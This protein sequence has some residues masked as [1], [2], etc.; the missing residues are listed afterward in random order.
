MDMPPPQAST[1]DIAPA[2]LTVD[3]GAIAA[4]WRMLAERS[5]RAETSAVLKADAYGLGAAPVAQALSG[6]GC[7][8]FFVAT[9]TEGAELRSTLPD[10]RIFVLSGLWAGWE[11]QCFAN[12]LIPVI[13][14]V[15]Q[16]DFF[17]GLGRTHPHALY[18]DTGM[19][20]L[21]V[22]PEEAARLSTSGVA[23]P[24]MLMSHLA[25]SDEPTHPL[26]RQQLESFRT[27]SRLFPG[28]ESSLSSSAG[29]FLGS[30]YHFDLTRPGIAL[31]GGESVCGV[32]NPMRQ[33]VTAEARILQIR[34]VTAGEKVS[35]G[36]TQTLARD[37]RVAVVGAGYADGW[38]R[39]LSGSGVALR[40]AGSP[41]AFGFVAGQKV[42]VIGRVTMDLTM[43]DITDIDKSHVKTGDY[44]S[45]FGNG[46]TLDEAARAAGTIGYELLTSLGRRYERRYV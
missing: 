23:A 31:Y 15:E 38:H 29:I 2:R 20:R 1:F 30:G 18:V 45:L 3:T 25:C 10:A 24:V 19:N 46:I 4:N 21:G 33:V 32:A 12:G 16:F 43:F 26:N 11:D 27:V 7:R 9:V 8:T 42:P 39:S 14:S 5:G 41:G 34:D 40:Q 28:V 17:Q 22:H 35:Y 44:I 36:A 37:S 6:A 13:A